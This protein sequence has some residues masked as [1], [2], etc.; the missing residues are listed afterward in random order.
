MRY[1]AILAATALLA[2]LGAAAADP[3]VI[4]VV[5]KADIRSTEPGFNRDDIT[6]VVQLHLAE[7]LVGY[8]HDG[9][10]RPLLAERVDISPDGLTYTFPLRHGVRFHTGTEMTSADVLWS[11]SYYMDPKRDWRCRP[12]FDGRNGL[13]VE[14]VEAPDAY[15]VRYRINKPS[16][17]FLATLARLD[18]GMT[19]II[20]RESLNPDGSWK[21]PVGTAPF[22]LA[23]W[24]RGEYVRLVKFDGYAN[25]GGK[26]DGYTG[27]KRPLVDEVR[28]VVIPD[29]ATAKAAL[30]K[31]GVDV[32]W[33]L[34][35]ADVAELKSAPN[36]NIEVSPSAGI[37]GLLL[38]T[39]DPLLSNVKMR[40][41]IAAAID[42][43]QVVEG[44]TSGLGI[45]N[46][47]IVPTSSA[48]HGKVQ[49][50]GVA[51]DPAAAAKLLAEAGYKGQPLTIIANQRYSQMFDAAVIIQAMLQA[52]G[53]NAT[54]EVLD[55][56]SELDRYSAGRFQMMAFSYSGRLDPSLSYEAMMGPKDKQPRKVWDNPKA[57]AIL[58]ASMTV[59]DPAR[60]Q[61]DFDRLH[62]LFL[63]DL[64]MIMLYNTVAPS[65]I[66]KG[67]S[68]YE[69]GA[70]SKPRLWEVSIAR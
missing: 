53:I 14:S 62:R 52:A 67:L 65:A 3:S 37:T 42:V 47:S 48:F 54:L 66:F 25:R 57:Q 69:T 38:Q 16:A 59:S 31:E 58:D 56:A 10:P 34:A 32:I 41:A 20:S 26:P 35:N 1:R 29:T 2:S 6:D 33:D 60:R 36:L 23:E 22:R 45:P 63:A 68:G 12:E 24:K 7:G 19:G 4:R 9:T 61:A 64:P 27:S 39:R 46:P 70:S 17:L 13:K 18:C 30:L 43:K 49:D 40:Q 11:W 51:Y 28:F 15:T 50:Q 8:G 55:W 21:A 44:V 5:I